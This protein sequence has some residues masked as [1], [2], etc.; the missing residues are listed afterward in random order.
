MHRTQY[1]NNKKDEFS[2]DNCIILQV[3]NVIGA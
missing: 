2:L 3:N 1:I